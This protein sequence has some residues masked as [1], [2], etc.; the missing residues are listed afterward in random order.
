MKKTQKE[1]NVIRQ[2]KFPILNFD[3]NK[4]AKLTIQKLDGKKCQNINYGV[5]C[6]DM[7]AREEFAQKYPSKII[8]TS[9]GCGISPLNIY[10]VNFNG[11]NIILHQ[12]IVGAPLA[13]VVME[14]LVAFGC[15]NIIAVGGAGVLKPEI[16]RGHLIIPT[17]AVRQEGTSY[18]Y[19][20]PSK[21][22]KCPPQVVKNMC[23]YLK[24]KGLPFVCGRTW[25][26][27]AIFRETQDLIDLRTK[28]GCICVEM[29]NATFAAVAQ[30]YNIKF[31]QILYGGDSLCGNVWDKRD[32]A[33][34][35]IKKR[36]HFELL[37]LAMEMVTKI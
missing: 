16:A 1:R 4:N 24:E 17:S 28:E 25:T 34:E 21:Y 7:D 5:I 19:I 10:A 9:K 12:G 37:K 32:W 26:T 31:G 33:N 13:A 22:I 35:D 2:S 3:S 36:T 27:D 30:F 18:H 14:N 23:K 15:K 11:A 29:E 6:F 20:A 8:G